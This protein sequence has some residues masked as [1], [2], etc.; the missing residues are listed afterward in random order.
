MRRIDPFAADFWHVSGGLCGN[1]SRLHV[2]Q[3]LMAVATVARTPTVIE[4]CD[5]I[6]SG[7]RQPTGGP[8]RH[9]PRSR[10]TSVLS[11]TGHSYGRP[12]AVTVSRP[13]C[14]SGTGSVTSLGTHGQPPVTDRDEPVSTPAA[15]A[16]ELCALLTDFGNMARGTMGK[17]FYLDAYKRVGSGGPDVRRCL[18][19]GATAR[20]RQGKRR[21]LLRV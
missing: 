12:P 2:G 1:R 14:G 9:V 16:G 6:R 8:P 13:T 20:D 4:G 19:P 18:R 15:A 11:S 10:N 21:P 17:P 3:R 5:P 7:G